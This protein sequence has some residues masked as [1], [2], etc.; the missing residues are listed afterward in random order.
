MSEYVDI[1]LVKLI[2]EELLKEGGSCEAQILITLNPT[3]RKFL[4][5]RKLVAYIIGLLVM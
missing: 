2:I 5:D 1:R 3:L 4:G